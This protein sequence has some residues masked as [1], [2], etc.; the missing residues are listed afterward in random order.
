MTLIGNFLSRPQRHTSLNSTPSAVPRTRNLFKLFE[1]HNVSMPQAQ[2]KSS[3]LSVYSWVFVL[4]LF[5]SGL[6]QSG[7]LQHFKL[8]ASSIG[9]FC[10]ASNVSFNLV[11]SNLV[12][13][14]EWLVYLT[15]REQAGS[16]VCSDGVFG[17]KQGV[18]LM[19]PSP[20][21]FATPLTY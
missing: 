9:L 12:E 3:S 11:P 6:A 13:I 14:I 5:S 19:P 16:A 4:G 15:R 17:C 18:L 2:F 10:T 1:N 7:T 8:Q 20:M 21:S